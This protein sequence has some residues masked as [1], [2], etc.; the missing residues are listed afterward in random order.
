MNRTARNG[1]IVA[2]AVAALLG[3][4]AGGQL[5]AAA[6]VVA[7][8]AD[9]V[10]HGSIDSQPSDDETVVVAHNFMGG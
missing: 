2:A 1:A 5:A 4:V 9:S 6:Q 7:R 8:G 10:V 3:S